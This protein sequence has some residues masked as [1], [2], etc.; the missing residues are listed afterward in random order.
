MIDIEG[1]S[2]Q[3][4]IEAKQQGEGFDVELVTDWFPNRK[5]HLLPNELQ[6]AIRDARSQEIIG[7][8]VNGHEDTYADARTRI[9]TEISDFESEITT[10]INDWNESQTE[11]E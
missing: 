2:V 8:R 9:D 3:P 7:F 1:I 4:K 5:N 6:N 10:F 11:S